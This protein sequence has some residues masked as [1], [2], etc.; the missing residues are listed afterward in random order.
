MKVSLACLFNE[1]CFSPMRI[2]T[3]DWK[4]FPVASLIREKKVNASL[5]S[6][7]QSEF[8]VGTNNGKKEEE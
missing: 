5:I 8:V 1:K 4:I 2:L 6:L 7:K 3:H